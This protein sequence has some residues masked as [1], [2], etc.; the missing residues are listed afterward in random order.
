MYTSGANNLRAEDAQQ[1]AE[2]ALKAVI[3]ASDRHPR[4]THDI[5]ALIAQI[6]EIE[7]DVPDTV[8]AASQLSRF[9]GTE[10]YELIG[11]DEPQP[12]DDETRQAVQTAR[13]TVDWSNE[14]VRERL[15]R[16]AA[17]SRE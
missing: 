15:R 2:L 17:R 3:V 14:R 16:A 13:A 9:G 10:S 4:R 7:K 12:S 6:Q 11:G 1:A 5:N 8:R